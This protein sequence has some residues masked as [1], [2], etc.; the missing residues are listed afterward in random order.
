VL[1]DA[2]HAL[3]LLTGM[4]DPN[5]YLLAM[6]AGD[7][8]ALT[9]LA[10]QRLYAAKRA[11][12]DRGAVPTKARHS[13]AVRSRP[14]VAHALRISAASEMSGCAMYD[15]VSAPG[16]VTVINRRPSG[17]N[18]TLVLRPSCPGV[19]SVASAAPVV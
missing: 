14:A 15:T 12:R 19:A 7:L 16:A 11:G 8:R 18:A 10:D 2:R 4:S 3:E 9:E 5:P 13:S 1:S 17:E 6:T